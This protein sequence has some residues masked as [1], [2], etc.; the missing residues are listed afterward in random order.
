INPY[1]GLIVEADNQKA[2]VRSVSGGRVQLDFN[3]EM[4]GKTLVYDLKIEKVLEKPEEQVEGFFEK[5]FPYAPVSDQK[6]SV[7]GKDVKI[8]LSEKAFDNNVAQM[9]KKMFCTD[10]FKFVNGVEN[11]EF[12]EVFK[13]PSK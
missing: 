1:P 2:R 8:E 7:K 5:A 10:V 9:S 3:N 11:V 12:N 4:A 13:K 6:F